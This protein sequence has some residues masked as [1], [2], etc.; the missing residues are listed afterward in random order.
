LPELKYL[1][2]FANLNPM[3]ARIDRKRTILI[4]SVNRAADPTQGGDC[5]GRRMAV[6]IAFTHTN[7]RYSRRERPH[8]VELTSL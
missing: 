4:S 6:S 8:K 5:L 1:M 2:A 3:S 7:Y